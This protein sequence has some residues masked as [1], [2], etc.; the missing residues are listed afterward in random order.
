MFCSNSIKMSNILLEH[1]DEINSTSGI[2]LNYRNSS[3][4][5]LCCGGGKVG[6]GTNSPSY[7]FDVA[8]EMRSSGF[9]HAM[10]NNDSYVLLAGGGALSLNSFVGWTSKTEYRYGEKYNLS[11][12]KL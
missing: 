10:Y 1:T 5:S 12:V 6:I 2:H 7:K 4:V 8:G 3:N 11:F 9:H